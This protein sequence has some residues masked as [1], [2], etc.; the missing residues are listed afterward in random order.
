LEE[1]NHLREAL[2]VSP[3]NVPLRKYLA[4]LLMKQG[5][6]A[7]AEQEYK[8][9]LRLAHTD[10]QLKVGLATAFLEQGK[11]SVGLV[12][13]EELLSQDRPPARAWLVYAK[14][15]YAQAQYPEAKDAY[16]KA[17]VIDPNLADA[18]WEAQLNLKLAENGPSP[19]KIKLS[20][21]GEEDDGEGY[22]GVDVERPK[23][24]FEHV[25]GME[26]IKDEIRLKIIHPLAH[27]EIYKA[28][29]KKI[30]GGILLYGPPG[31]GK[32][33]L[34]RATAGEIKTNFISVGISEV[35]DMYIGQ[36]EQN[37]HALFER[38]RQYK[39]CVL[40]FDEV[41]ALGASRTDM[42]HSAGRQLINQF[43]A[44]M[45]GIDASNEGVL[46]LAATNA[47]W[48][49]DPAFR[50]PGRFDRIVFVPPPDE[51][52]RESIL[53]IMLK[54]KPTEPLDLRQLAKATPDFSGADLKAVVDLAVEE[55]LL[56]AM[57][58]GAPLPLSTKD[59]LA[60]AKKH[61]PTT[62]EWFTTAK[63]Y[64]IFSNE[65]GQYDDILKYMNLKK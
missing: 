55:K 32:T 31:C 52:A 26:K 21:Y 39:P 57:K 17:T 38:A 59:L 56:E 13:A 54:D 58:R 43:L 20:H 51:P 64:A 19:E 46:V 1:I 37:L 40:F 9:A 60:A 3:D 48:H 42:R 7:E 53:Q 49:L 16:E 12:L 33:H 5:Q 62:K 14:L 27:P 2:Q 63:N 28:Y 50:R 65:S 18:Y 11:I 45:D 35:L 34:A 10:N 44:E 22:S 25:G 29:G 36:S 23:E 61:K 15:L 47:P 41:D 24:N 8:T 4:D 6:F 30:G